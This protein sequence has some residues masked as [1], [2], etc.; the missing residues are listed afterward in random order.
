MNA[1]FCQHL[2]VREQGRGGERER[3]FLRGG[4]FGK[5]DQSGGDDT[6][7]SV[8]EEVFSEPLVEYKQQCNNEKRQKWLQFNRMHSFMDFASVQRSLFIP[9]ERLKDNSQLQI[10]GVRALKGQ[11]RVIR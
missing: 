11:Q 8:V 4:G 9:W 10:Q 6:F 5:A 7:F 1:N 2:A 3:S